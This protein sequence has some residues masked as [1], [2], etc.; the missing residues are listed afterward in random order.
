[1]KNK[2]IN[3]NV[4]IPLARI[5]VMAKSGGLKALVVK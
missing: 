5:V 2:E 4:Y 3:G 1:M